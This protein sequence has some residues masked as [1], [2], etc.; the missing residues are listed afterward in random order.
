MDLVGKA[1]RVRV[2]V[3]ESDVIGR[4]LAP[5]AIL[6]WLRQERVA[7]AI[8][9]RGTAGFG[10]SGRIDDD[11]MP[12]L[13]P[14]LPVIVEWVDAP[15]RRAPPAAALRAGGARPDPGRGRADRPLPRRRARAI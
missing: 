9:L 12:E 2:Y 6:E 3:K 14:H 11:V 5:Q 7:G 15:K 13:A 10:S 4:R 8:L 1:K